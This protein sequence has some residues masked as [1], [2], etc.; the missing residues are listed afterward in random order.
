MKK[1]LF[2]MLT[3]LVILIVGCASGAKYALTVADIEPKLASLGGA[4]FGFADDS[5]DGLVT[6]IQIGDAK[7]DDFFK[8]AAKLDGLVIV[9]QAMT[10]SATDQL[11]KYAMSKAASAAMQDN[12]AELVGDTPKEEWTTEQSIAVL[13]M[14]KAQGNINADELEYF[15]TTSASIGIAV[16]SLG[17]GINEAKDLVPKGKQLLENVKSVSPLQIPSATKGIKAS[18]EN[19]NNVIKNAPKMLEEMKVLAD[20][21]MALK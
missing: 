20:G 6:Y 7:Y 12:I 19:L 17:K 3:V 13:K 4:N 1:L 16:I 8:S 2:G 18:L 14:A 21:F 11:K 10:T 5:E 15:I 9:T